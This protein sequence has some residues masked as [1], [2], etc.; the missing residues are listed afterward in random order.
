MKPVLKG[1]IAELT[2]WMSTIRKICKRDAHVTPCYDLI[3]SLYNQLFEKAGK[4]IILNQA[5]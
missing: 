5:A 3:I 2:F 4:S 1:L